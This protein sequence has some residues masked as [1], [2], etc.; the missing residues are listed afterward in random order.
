MIHSKMIHLTNKVC[1][2]K[3]YFQISISIYNYANYDK[4]RNKKI[5]S[6]ADIKISIKNNATIES[7]Q[8]TLTK[9]LIFQLIILNSF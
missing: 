7:Y 1:T 8:R 6:K 4:Q 5:C 3:K 9:F 2:D